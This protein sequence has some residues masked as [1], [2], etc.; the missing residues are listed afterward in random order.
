[1]HC[2]CIQ[3]PARRSGRRG[4]EDNSPRSC[5]GIVSDAVAEE[6][7]GPHCIP[8]L[9][10]GPSRHVSQAQEDEDGEAKA[11]EDKDQHCQHG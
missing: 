8:P 10:E 3:V 9:R 2:R 7:E 5:C 6:Q 4:E 1:M 11:D